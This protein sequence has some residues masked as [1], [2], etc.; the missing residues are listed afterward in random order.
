MAVS[1][2]STVNMPVLK[3]MKTWLDQ[4][5][6]LAPRYIPRCGFKTET[7]GPQ[8]IHFTAA[9]SALSDIGERNMKF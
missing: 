6:K 9:P 2:E 3:K 5:R 4:I 8:D 7:F 1:E